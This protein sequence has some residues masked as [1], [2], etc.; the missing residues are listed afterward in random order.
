MFWFCGNP[1]RAECDGKE[2]IMTE[3]FSL[4]PVK[5]KSEF[6]RGS[7]LRTCLAQDVALL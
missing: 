5:G 7:V 2:L 3:P 6:A 1:T 4:W